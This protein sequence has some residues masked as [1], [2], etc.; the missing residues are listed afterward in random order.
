[1]DLRHWV[2]NIGCT[3]V[4]HTY[5]H[6]YIYT[7]IHTYTYTYIHTYIYTHMHTYTYT[8]IYIHTHI[9]IYT[10]IYIHIHIHYIHTHTYITY[11]HT[12]HTCIP[13]YILRS[14]PALHR[15]GRFSRWKTWLGLKDGFWKACVEVVKVF[16]CRMV[17]LL[18]PLYL[19]SFLLLWKIT[20]Q[21]DQSITA[22]T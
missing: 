5:I 6:T 8:Y 15:Q 13:T 2:L 17:G 21:C 16:L 11:I 9:H 20:T 10:Y 3:H 7:H 19:Q 14:S 4:I 12:L 18:P 22:P 1:V